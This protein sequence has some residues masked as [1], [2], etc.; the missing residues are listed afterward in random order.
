MYTPITT[1]H[2]LRDEVTHM[3]S[4]EE[5]EKRAKHE[6]YVEIFNLCRDS[7][8]FNPMIEV[9]TFANGGNISEHDYKT[10]LRIA[11]ERKDLASFVSCKK[12]LGE[13]VSRDELVELDQ[14]YVVA[15]TAM[16]HL[17]GLVSKHVPEWKLSP[18]E[19]LL[20]R[21]TAF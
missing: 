6:K 13:R 15:D 10:C 9:S 7:G 4:S 19:W 12:V 3:L 17:L 11:L 20:T 14:E 8:Y 21:C 2:R 16:R 1:I 18:E 5:H